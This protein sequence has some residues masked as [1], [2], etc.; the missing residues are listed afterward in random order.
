[1]G[2]NRKTDANET[3]RAHSEKVVRVCIIDGNC[4][5]D[6]QWWSKENPKICAKALDLIE[7]VLREPFTGLGKPEPLKHL[8]ANTWSR[9][10]TGEHRLVYV[11][12]SDRVNFVMAR[13]HY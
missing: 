9:R 5:E 8:G 12:F 6:L 7:H 13:Y 4:V 10:L 1:M 3:N 11:V 2:K